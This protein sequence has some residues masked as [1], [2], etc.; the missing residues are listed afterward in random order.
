VVQPSEEARVIRE[1]AFRHVMSGVCSP[2]TIVT[3][4]DEGKPHGATPPMI[5]VALDQ[6]SRLL[7]ALRSSG[8][9]G[10]NILHAAQQELATKFA[11]S[12]LDRF[13]GTSWEL[14]HDLPRLSGSAGWIA[15]RVEDAMRGGDHVLIFGRVTASWS[16][17]APPLVYARHLFGT[18]SGLIT[19]STEP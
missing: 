15:C 6:R 12:E 17:S 4:F 2:V 9:F 3:T 8:Y 10:V 13:N 7:H 19:P 16:S 5:S 1:E 11:R 18:H 14:D